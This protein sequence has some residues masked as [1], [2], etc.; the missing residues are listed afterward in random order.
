M[1]L[2]KT[3]QTLSFLSALKA[4]GMPG[5]HLV[6]TPLA[7]LQNWHNEIKRFTPGLSVIKVHGSRSE[8]DRILSMPVVLAGGF[9]IYLTTYETVLSEEPFFT[10]SFLFHT[11]TID[12]GHRLKNES[13]QLCASLARLTVPFRLLLTGTPLQNNLNE[14]WALMHYILPDALEGCKDTFDAACSLEEGQLDRGVVDQARALLES[15]MLRRI[16]SEVETTLLPK[17]HWVLKVPLTALQRQWYRRFLSKDTEAQ[18]LVTRKQLIAKIQQLQ[19]IINHPKVILYALDREREQARSMQQRAEGSQFISLPQVLGAQTESAQKMEAELRNLRGAQLIESSGKLHLLD[20]LLSRVRASGSRVLLFS[21][22]TMTLDVLA[23]YCESRFG[24]EGRG[25]LRLDGSTN[26]IKREMDVRAFNAPNSR[27][28]I[29]LIS[30]RAGGQGINLASAD[31]VVLYDTCWNPQVDLQAQD[32]AHRIGQKKQVKVFRLIAEATLEER[33]LTRARQKLVLDALVIKNKGEMSALANEV[34]ND[35]DSSDEAAMEKLSLDE[36]W[37]FLSFGSEDVLGPMSEENVQPLSEFDLDRIIDQGS[38]TESTAGVESEASRVPATLDLG[39][40]AK[41]RQKKAGP[42]SSADVDL[43]VDASDDSDDERGGKLRK[44]PKPRGRTPAG[45]RWNY[46]TGI[47]VPNNATQTSATST[48]TAAE[49][50]G[51]LASAAEEPSSINVVST[52]VIRKALGRGSV[53]D[54]LLRERA[55]HPFVSCQDCTQRV[56]GLGETKMKQLQQAGV[57]FPS[58]NAVVQSE[59]KDDTPSTISPQTVGGSIAPKCPDETQT[60]RPRRQN[61]GQLQRYQPPLI[62]HNKAKRRKLRH[63]D[64][65]FSCEDGGELLECSVCPKVYHPTSECA[66]LSDNKVP[67]GTW[68]CPWH[69]CWECERKSSQAGG[70]LFHC[71]EC[72][73]AYCFDCAPDKYTTQR[74]G[75]TAH[76]YIAAMLENRGCASTKS[77][78]FFTCDDCD[79]RRVAREK[80]EEEKRELQQKRAEAERQR[81]IAWNRPEAVAARAEMAKTYNLLQAERAEK[82]REQAAARKQAAASASEARQAWEQRVREAWEQHLDEGRGMVYWWNRITHESRWTHPDDATVSQAAAQSPRETASVAAAESAAAGKHADVVAK[83]AVPAAAACSINVVSKDVIRKALGRGSV[84]NTLLRERA[85]R[86]FASRRDCTRRVSG[87]GETKMKQLEQAGVTF[88]SGKVEKQQKKAEPVKSGGEGRQAWEQRLRE[89][90]EQHLDAKTGTMYWW[91]RITHDSRW[92][93]PDDAVVLQT[94]AES[95]RE[96]ASVAAAESAAAGEHADV[97]AK[98][99][100]PAAALA[101]PSF[102]STDSGQQEI[103]DLTMDT[104]RGPALSTSVSVSNPVVAKEEQ[105][106]IAS[107]SSNAGSRNGNASDRDSTSGTVS[108]KPTIKKSKKLGRASAAKARAAAAIAEALERR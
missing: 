16:K 92:T 11:I 3:L 60:T 26:R 78:L 18:A 71:T 81:L 17:L 23:E 6:V 36:L 76:K 107:G 95:P 12:E 82:R 8:R 101:T 84:A 80:A 75:T 66:G 103:L 50:V 10:E 67:K 64:F 55:N 88:P 83:Q 41:P 21:Q 61:A 24:P 4:A 20:R 57:T 38:T 27:I 22:F 42:E 43:T 96:T 19:K 74:T 59:L 56:S 48:S 53:A 9:D 72:P 46:K 91:N 85:E 93:L 102:T 99:A 35:T 100:V 77:Y 44:F 32:R 51:Q 33:V 13:G 65:C 30:T 2:G 94:A 87:L 97:V 68:I 49:A 25:F 58:G 54:Q 5:P 40:A 106:P 52:E 79:P 108:A 69:A 105:T 86:P 37:S 45:M 34:G 31:V 89:A 29:Y 90:W 28:P 47:W 15:L 104:G 73:L 98:Q 7:V 62:H 1:G 14:L 63:E 39:T 70:M